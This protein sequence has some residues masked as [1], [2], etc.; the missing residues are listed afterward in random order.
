MSERAI[1]VLAHQSTE[2]QF[3][4]KVTSTVVSTPR[5]AFCEPPRVRY[6]PFVVVP[7]RPFS[8]SPATSPV[9]LMFTDGITG[10]SPPVRARP[11]SPSTSPSLAS[12]PVSTTALRAS[13]RQVHLPTRAESLLVGPESLSPTAFPSVSANASAR[14]LPALQLQPVLVDKSDG[15]NHVSA[16]DTG[17]TALER[18]RGL[19]S[20][21]LYCMHIST[22]FT[23]ILMLPF[24]RC[25]CQHRFLRC[26]RCP[27]LLQ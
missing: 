12:P 1:A 24:L 2:R 13:R 20:L 11:I 5:R 26:R 10:T 25:L 15:G 27:L 8:P 4:V 7:R 17:E 14:F 21:P 16:W 9:S 22:L 19:V 6:H 18:D 23:R 3:E